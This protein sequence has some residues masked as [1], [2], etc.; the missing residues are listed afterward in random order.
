M[1]GGIALAAEH[2]QS[3]DQLKAAVKRLHRAHA[4]TAAEGGPP[5]GAA[6]GG[7][8]GGAAERDA[9]EVAASEAA[10]R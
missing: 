5:K 3:P 10:Q 2:I 4:S 7:A 6:G 1:Q 8:A 9:G